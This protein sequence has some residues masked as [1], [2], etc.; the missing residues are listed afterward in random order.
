MPGSLLYDFGDG[1]NYT[2]LSAFQLTSGTNWEVNGLETNPEL[3]P[4]DYDE[5]LHY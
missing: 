5:E 3:N 1:N 4:L 2:S